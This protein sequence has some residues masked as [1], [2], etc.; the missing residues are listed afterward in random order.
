MLPD[1]RNNET[2][3]ILSACNTCKTWYDDLPINSGFAR[4]MQ[5]SGCFVIWLDM[6]RNYDFNQFDESSTEKKNRT[7]CACS[8][9]C[10][11]EGLS[12][13]VLPRSTILSN[14]DAQFEEKPEPCNHLLLFPNLHSSKCKR[15]TITK[16]N[17]FMCLSLFHKPS[18]PRKARYKRW[19]GGLGFVA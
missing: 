7:V 8:E 9:K 15:E 16:Y 6:C 14:N 2:K 18:S 4:K 1:I 17:M 11:Y 19:A 3:P 12:L 13:Y 10:I 5:L